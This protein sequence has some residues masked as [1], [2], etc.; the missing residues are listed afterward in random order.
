[1]NYSF[2]FVA[3]TTLPYIFRL[4]KS[5][6]VNEGILTNVAFER[7][8][9]TGESPLGKE[10]FERRLRDQKKTSGGGGGGGCNKDTF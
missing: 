10:H 6:N 5:V 8:T 2:I 1:M 4:H 9:G 7:G 3:I